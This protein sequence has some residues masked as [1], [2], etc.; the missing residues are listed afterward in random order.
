MDYYRQI[1]HASGLKMLVY[2]LPAATKISLGLNELEKLFDDQF[3]GV[4]HTSSDFFAL[5][6]IKSHFPDK[7]IFNGY[8]E[9]FL[10]G[11]AAAHSVCASLKGFTAAG[12]SSAS[13]TR[14][15]ICSR[16]RG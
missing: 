1:A 11:L 6:G 2:N 3:L 5:E 16:S 10:S 13:S 4:K 9:M 7:Y 15:R 12:S 14:R 8:D